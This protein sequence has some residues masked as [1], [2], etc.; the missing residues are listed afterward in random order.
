MP[1]HYPKTEAEWLALRHQYISSTESAPLFGLGSYQT[2]YELGIS[3]QAKE[4][5]ASLDS[6]ERVRWGK[7][8]QE[9]IAKGISEEY[10]VRV[11]RVTGYAV[12]PECRLGASFDYEIVGITKGEDGQ[13]LKVEDPMLQQMYRD[14]GPGVLEIKNVDRL[15]FKR[16]W[17]KEDGELEAPPQFEIQVQHQLEAIQT[18]TWA[19]IGVLVGGNEAILVLRER[20]EDFGAAIRAKVDAFWADLAQG[21]LPPIT[22]PQDV[23]IIRRIY[24]SSSAGKVYDGSADEELKQLC[25]HYNE[26]A[27]LAKM[28]E[29]SRKTL[30]AKI[31]MKIGDAERAT[32]AGFSIAAGTVPETWVERYLRK[33][34]RNV[35]VTA[36]KPKDDAAPA[37]KK[38][39]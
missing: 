35:R 5:P 32:A 36:L 12:H 10:G 37:A 4:P 6:N 27:A 16:E 13:E 23:E 31:L 14:L 22:L 8:L 17:K 9:A 21:K 7:R 19:A 20:D 26:T 34:Y 15:I 30:G 29:E 25:T 24:L 3:K 18:R 11:R 39:S 1:M 38:A 28:Y 33:A 2:P